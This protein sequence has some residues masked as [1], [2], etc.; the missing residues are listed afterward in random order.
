MGEI[1]WSNST[2]SNATPSDGTGTLWL[3]TFVASQPSP[4]TTCWALLENP[5][6]KM[7]FVWRFHQDRDPS[8]SGG[9]N[10]INFTKKSCYVGL[11][12]N[13][14]LPSAGW[15][16]P[17]IF[18]G[19]RYDTDTTSPSINDST[20]H[21]EAVGNTLNVNI[22][23][24]AVRN[25]TQGTTVDTGITPSKGTYYRLDIVCVAAGVVQM[26]IN[27]SAPQT[28]TIPLYTADNV[29][30]SASS[31]TVIAT[32]GE[33]ILY[34]GNTGS[35][36]YL[37]PF[38]TGSQVAISG[39]TG[40]NAALNGNHT[41]V[42]AASQ[43][44]NVPRIMNFVFPTP[45]GLTNPGVWK[46]IGYPALMPIVLFGNDSSASPSTNTKMCVDYFSFVMN[47]GIAT[48]SATPDPTKSRYFG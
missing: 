44:L 45:I 4:S 19:A 32:N 22:T 9:G 37:H 36:S 31:D 11:A 2:T 1:A 20:I 5:G 46:A 8:N 47:A 33:A 39:F 34:Y 38:S 27:G 14:N 42:Q 48:A 30:I 7:T 29:G 15:S 21:L 17:L 24:A 25:N 16:R 41:L 35:I 40:G 13:N 23:G 28:F 10:A 26:S 12:T 6:W 3:N 18:I 43:P